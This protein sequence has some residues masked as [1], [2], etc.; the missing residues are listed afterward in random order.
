VL[1]GYRTR[2]TSESK[3]RHDL[4]THFDAQSEQH[5]VAELSSAEPTIAIVAEEG[6]RH[7]ATGELTWYVDPLD[8]T[9]NFVH[10]HPIWS[11]SIGLARGCDPVVGAVVAPAL[12]VAWHGWIGAGAWRNDER[13]RVSTTA[14]LDDALVATGFPAV[15]D[16]AP[17]DNLDAFARVK[18]RCR[19]VRR[20]G[21][22]A[23]DLCMVAD[24][25]YDGYWERRLN[26]WDTMAGAALALAAG[27]QSTSL[28]GGAVDYRTGHLV[29][30]NGLIHDALVRTI[31]A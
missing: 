3:G 10:G 27:G 28:G 21:S 29:V 13:C 1:A 22:A 25:T 30:S 8:G 26:A 2:P 20:C 24:G 16:R 5:I 14:E 6:G 9:T 31:A 19:G 11:V 4:V 18:R 17:D 12:G 7:A 23:V 15:A